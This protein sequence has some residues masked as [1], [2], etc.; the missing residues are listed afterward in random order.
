MPNRNTFSAD[1]HHILPDLESIARETGFIQR[2]S[3]KLSAQGF[4]VSVLQGVTQGSASSNHLALQLAQIEP[5]SMSRQ[6]MHQRFSESSSAFLE[7]VLLRLTFQA[8]RPSKSSAFRRI[9]VEDSTVISMGD[10]NTEHFPGNGTQAGVSAGGKINLVTDWITGRVIETGLHAAKEPDQ[11]LAPDLLDEVMEDDLVLR[12][13]GYFTFDSLEVIESRNAFWI[14]RLPA[15]IRAFDGEATPLEEILK[16]SRSNQLDIDIWLGRDRGHPCRLIA[17]RLPLKETEKN[18][19]QRRRNSKRHGATTAKKGLIYDGWSIHITN[20][21]KERFGSDA[22]HRL[23][24]IRWSIEIHFRAMKQS[25]H[26]HRGLNQKSNYHHL[27]TMLLAL[28]IKTVL[29]MNLEM[30][31]RRSLGKLSEISI[32]KLSDAFSIY[33]TQL[34]GERTESPVIFDPRHVK[35]EKRKRLSLYAAMTP[36]L[37]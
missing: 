23:Y 16:Q 21:P 5:Q 9:L 26:L 25:S 6:A 24:S 30:R 36:L 29:T 31:M 2:Q 7:E 18:R 8:R 28:M 17:T 15:N 27:K 14:S 1:L 11:K 12:D 3:H 37:T 35:K 20:L 4:L 10:G 32:E 19:R 22:I 13:R 34:Q 33:L